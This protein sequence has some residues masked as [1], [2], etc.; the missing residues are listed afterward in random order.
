MWVVDTCVV[1]DILESDPT[2]GLASA[3]CLQDRLT[4]GLCVSPV[5]MVEL[6]PAFGG[7]LQEQKLFMDLAGIAHSE[8]WTTADTESAHQAWNLCVQS[9][10]RSKIP[11]RPVADLLIGAFAWRRSG[12]I[13]RNP[14]D[15]CPWFPGLVILEP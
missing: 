13:T 9:R 7:D 12:L 15:F 6:S 5:T 11:K 14:G 2:F 4:E 10:R 8:P 3:Q 1:L